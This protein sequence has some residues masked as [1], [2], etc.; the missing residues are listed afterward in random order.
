LCKLTQLILE[1]VTCEI[2][3]KTAE[4]CKTLQ[5]SPTVFSFVE[6]SRVGRCDRGRTVIIFMTFVQAATRKRR[7]NQLQLAIMKFSRDA[8]TQ[9]EVRAGYNYADKSY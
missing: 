7:E 3:L 1:T 2:Q 4:M 6:F 5:N 9:I 8:H